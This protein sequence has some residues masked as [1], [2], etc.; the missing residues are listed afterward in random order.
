MTALIDAM[1]MAY[2]GGVK[3]PE[4]HTCPRCLPWW[5]PQQCGVLHCQPNMW[6]AAFLA[7]RECLEMNHQQ[8]RHQVSRKQQEF[9]LRVRVVWCTAAESLPRTLADMPVEGLTFEFGDVRPMVPYEMG[10]W[11]TGFSRTVLHYGPSGRLSSIRFDDFDLKGIW[12]H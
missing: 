8:K 2:P 7:H 1:Y 11:G 6:P 12:D 9:T 10:G 3:I 4:R 5:L